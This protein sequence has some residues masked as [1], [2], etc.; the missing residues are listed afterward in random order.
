MQ[1][2]YHKFPVEKFMRS[3]RINWN[4]YNI[5]SYISLF[6]GVYQ[7]AHY[8]V[9]GQPVFVCE[10]WG[11]SMKYKCIIQTF[12]TIKFPYREKKVTLLIHYSLPAS[13]CSAHLVFQD[14]QCVLHIQLYIFY[15][16]LDLFDDRYY[17][18]SKL[19][20]LIELELGFAFFFVVVKLLFKTCMISNKK[21]SNAHS[22]AQV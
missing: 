8:S 12:D 9:K 18:F 10:L 17:T 7:S 20:R 14:T 22:N 2:K 4:S 13:I 21:I 19:S 3:S 11:L 15:K 16:Y 6:I 1:F 5:S